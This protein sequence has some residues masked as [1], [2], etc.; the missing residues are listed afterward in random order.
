MKRQE[1]ASAQDQ[2]QNIRTIDCYS[3]LSTRTLREVGWVGGVMNLLGGD[4]DEFLVILSRK[5]G[6]NMYR[7][8]ELL[9]TKEILYKYVLV[10][11]NLPDSEV[12]Y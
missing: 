6:T 10:C 2:G 8:N 7:D 1:D 5:G 11:K 12:W 4:Q 9:R 3:S